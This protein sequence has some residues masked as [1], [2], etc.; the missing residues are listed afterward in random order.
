MEYIVWVAL[1]GEKLKR[2]K[3][4]RL[5]NQNQFDHQQNYLLR[6]IQKLKVLLALVINDFYAQ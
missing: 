5:L 2:D 3:L 4:D 6:G 1:S